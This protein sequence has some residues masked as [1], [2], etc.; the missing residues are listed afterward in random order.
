MM[1]KTLVALAA[2]AVTGGAFAQA[3]MTGAINYG[4]SQKQLTTGVSS[5]GLGFEGAAI[6]FNVAETIEGLGK[7]SGKMGISAKNTDTSAAAKD[8]VLK[9]DMG[10]SGA[11][12]M[13]SVYSASWLGG[14]ASSGSVAY[15]SFSSGDC[16]SGIGMFSTYGYNDDLSYS[17]KLSDSLA[18][19]VSHT[20]PSAASAGMGTGGTG[21]TIASTGNGA[22]YNTYSATYTAAPLV[23]TGGYR[24]YDLAQ[25]A[26]SNSNSRNRAAISYDLG[27]AKVS[28]GYEQTATT[29]GAT[30]TDTVMTIATAVPNSALSLSASFGTRAKAGNATSTDDSSYS[31]SIYGASYTL[32]PRTSLGMTYLTNQSTGTTNPN[33]FLATIN[34]SF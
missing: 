26:T 31:G 19:S 33:F 27:V 29:Y 13:Q 34:H 2:V 15:C 8:T 23:I 12:T 16:A 1:K 30:T 25:L 10:S 11:V 6:V 17:M 28:A 14:V 24:T 7:V 5:G 21:T 18:V 32:S 3:T 20:E 22:R 9:L 4:Y